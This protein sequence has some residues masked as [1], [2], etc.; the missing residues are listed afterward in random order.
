MIHSYDGTVLSDQR[1]FEVRTFFDI[2]AVGGIEMF[3]VVILPTMS[4]G[5]SKYRILNG[6]KP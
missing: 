1:V 6:K 3:G 5:R 2:V 4:E